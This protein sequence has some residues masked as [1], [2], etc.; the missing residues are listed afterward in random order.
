MQTTV[1]GGCK[2]RCGTATKL[3]TEPISFPWEVIPDFCRSQTK[4]NARDGI[5]TD[6]QFVIKLKTKDFNPA[7]LSSSGVI[8]E[9]MLRFGGCQ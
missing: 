7:C 1:L 4:A 3:G 8:G 6:L 2:P 9:E 5:C